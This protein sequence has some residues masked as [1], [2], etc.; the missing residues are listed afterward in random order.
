MAIIREARGFKPQ[1]GLKNFLAENCSIIGDVVTG[2]DCSIWYQVT[3]RGDVMPIRI[4]RQVNIQDGSI[5]HGTFGEYGVEIA[6]RVTIGHAVTL[7]GC[8]I[9]YESLI[10]MGSIIMDGAEIPEHCL[11]APCQ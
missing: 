11:I 3:I 4:G 8:K 2:E 1:L 10:G 7:H 6:D 5:I 9:G